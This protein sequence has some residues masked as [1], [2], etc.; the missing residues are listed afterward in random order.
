LIQS[1]DTWD[2]LAIYNTA[3]SYSIVFTRNDG[4]GSETLSTT[5]YHTSLGVY[6]ANITPTI[7]ATY[8]MVVRLSGSEISGSPYTV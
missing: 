4:L 1:R 6:R 2:N 8:A 5:A 3:D 7:A